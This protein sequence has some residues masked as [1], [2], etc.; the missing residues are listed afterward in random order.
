MFNKLRDNGRQIIMTCDRQP[1]EVKGLED[2]LISR[3]SGGVVVDIQPPRYTE[4]L[5]DVSAWM[6][7]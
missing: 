1:Q 3:F 5:R 4:K 2:R 6:H 7:S